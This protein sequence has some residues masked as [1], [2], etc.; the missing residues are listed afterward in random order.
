MA[1]TCKSL[2]LDGL[3]LKIRFQMVYLTVI[4]KATALT[5]WFSFY[6]YFRSRVRQG[7]LQADEQAPAGFD[8]QRAADGGSVAVE[9]GGERDVAG[10]AVDGLDV[11]G[12]VED[13]L[14]LLEGAGVCIEEA[15]DEG[16]HALLGL[17]V[18]DGPGVERGVDLT[19]CE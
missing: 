2:I 3:H 14:E 4:E 15:A 17:D 5:P 10:F 19:L 11:S 1:T 6:P 8:G 18:M 9:D 16:E 13:D 7:L 12:Q